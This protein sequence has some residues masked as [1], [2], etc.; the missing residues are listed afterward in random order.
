VDRDAVDGD[1]G[2]G[3]H[4]EC[5]PEAD[6][7]IGTTSAVS[8]MSVNGSAAAR[9]WPMAIRTN[10]EPSNHRGLTRA[11]SQDTSGMS[12]NAGL[13]RSRNGIEV[14]SGL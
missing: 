13:C 7:P 14:R 5:E 10:P 12:P 2:D 11:S 4:G 3:G 8:I 9:H 6:N 1:R